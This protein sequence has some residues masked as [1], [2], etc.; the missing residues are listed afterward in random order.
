MSAAPV[1]P[2]TPYSNAAPAIIAHPLAVQV[3]RA[4]MFIYSIHSLQ[5]PLGGLLFPWF[6]WIEAAPTNE[7]AAAF[8]SVTAS[9]EIMPDVVISGSLSRTRRRLR[10]RGFRG[11]ALAASAAALGSRHPL[12]AA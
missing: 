11:C 1:R 3:N 2:S 10:S 5:K 6:V 9:D 8:P 12:T 7:Y 4:S